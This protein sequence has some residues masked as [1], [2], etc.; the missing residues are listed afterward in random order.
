L[1]A[2]DL[3]EDLKTSGFIANPRQSVYII[4]RRQPSLDPL[5]SFSV[6]V[7]QCF[8]RSPAPSRF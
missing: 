8:S 6:S 2:I 5:L 3:K 4:A 1:T 7:F